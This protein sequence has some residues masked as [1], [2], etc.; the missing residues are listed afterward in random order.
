MPDQKPKLVRFDP[1]IGQVRDLGSAAST[2]TV[3][4]DAAPKLPRTPFNAITQAG[5]AIK[6][7]GVEECQPGRRV[8]RS[9]G[10]PS[11]QNRMVSEGQSSVPIVS[12]VA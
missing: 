4:R 8:G 1:S 3:A 10:L 6:K 9:Y 12:N 11:V 2:E 7:W 5:R